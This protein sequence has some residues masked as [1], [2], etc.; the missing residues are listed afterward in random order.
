MLRRRGLRVVFVLVAAATI[1]LW[2]AAAGAHYER[3]TTP[4]DG[5]GHLPTYRDSGQHLVVCKNDDAEFAR[6]IN[7]FP[8]ALQDVNRALYAECIQNGYRD[9]QA[10]VDHITSP[11]MTILVLPGVYLEEPSLAREADGCYHLPA[12]WVANVGY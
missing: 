11:G 8:A 5:T 10:A 12:Q 7:G 3:P 6:R 1:A 9:L 2:P 4:P